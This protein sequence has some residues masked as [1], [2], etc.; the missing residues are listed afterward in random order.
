VVAAIA[1]ATVVIFAPAAYNFSN[2]AQVFHETIQCDVQNKTCSFDS[3]ITTS[4]TTSTTTNPPT[5]H[6][7][8]VNPPS[9]TILRG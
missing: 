6:L 8:T 2:R 9:P 1:L 5:I 4:P 7:P 3:T